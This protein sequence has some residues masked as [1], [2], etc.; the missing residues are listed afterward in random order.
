VRHQRKVTEEMFASIPALV[1][2]GL[3]K[4]EIAE[5]FGCT[6]GTL[7]VLCSHRGISLRPVLLNPPT[8]ERVRREVRLTLEDDV[9]LSLRRAMRCTGRPSTAKLVADLLGAIASDN[10]YSA[11]LDEVVA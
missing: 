10:L 5:R 2:Q 6:P 4:A 9:L 8:S 1:E 7:A 3:R 11:V